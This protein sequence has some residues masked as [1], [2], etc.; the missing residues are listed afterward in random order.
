MGYLILVAVDTV[1]QLEQ[2]VGAL[3]GAEGYGNIDGSLGCVH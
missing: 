2:V 3:G 1:I